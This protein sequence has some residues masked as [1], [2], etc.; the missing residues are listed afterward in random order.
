M[1]K[2]TYFNWKHDESGV[3]FNMLGQRFFQ[4]IGESDTMIPTETIIQ[5]DTNNTTRVTILEEYQGEMVE[6]K[7]ECYTILNTFNSK[8]EVIAHET[9]LLLPQ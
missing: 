2:Y 5:Y 1:K 7:V 9:A 4:R 6:V 3:C 8:E